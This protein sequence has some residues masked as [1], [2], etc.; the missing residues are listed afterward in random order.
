MKISKLF[1]LIVLLIIGVIGYMI[2]SFSS[3]LKSKFGEFGEIAKMMGGLDDQPQFETGALS[4]DGD[5]FAY[6]Y[7]PDVIMP[8][9]K[10]NITIRGYQYHS[11]FQV[12]DTKTGQGLFK[13][14]FETPYKGDRFYIIDIQGDIVWILLYL[15]DDQ[16]YQL[17]AYDIKKQ[18]FRFPFGKINDLNPNFMEH[19]VTYYTNSDTHEG[20][21]VKGNDSRY[22]K[23]N[24]DTGKVEVANGNFEQIDFISPS[25]KDL[26]NYSM[27]GREYSTEM[28]N[29]D[30]VS[31]TLG[32]NI[33]STDDFIKVNVVKAI[34]LNDISGGL[35]LLYNNNFFVF[36]PTKNDSKVEQ[37]LAMIDKNTLKVQ[38]KTTLPQVEM[39][40]MIPYYEHE[41]FR[42]KGDK[43]LV[44]NNDYLMTIDLETGEI[45]RKVNLYE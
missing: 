35:P 21:F 16:I 2:Y 32:K 26:G 4:K 37:E 38:W 42:L 18:D 17:G 15:S 30:R 11:Y 13:K 45:E 19:I 36:S 40:T 31:I 20:I 41:L 22:Y 14:P 1:I 25:N 24:T 33:V 29:G 28:I 10:G 3:N 27:L 7:Q 6:T 8:K 5:Y 44:S 34:S 12:L 43:L 23:I 39:G 9:V